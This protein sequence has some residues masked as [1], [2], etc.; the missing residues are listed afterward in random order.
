MEYTDKNYTREE[1]FTSLKYGANKRRAI[2]EQL[3]RIYDIVYEL[4]ES[5]F[6]KKITEGLVDALWLAKLMGERLSYL[7]WKYHDTTGH[8]R[9]RVPRRFDNGTQRK[10]KQMRRTRL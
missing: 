4:P 8:L 7:F 5:D 1:V 9:Y 2:C 3:R 10:V 6:K